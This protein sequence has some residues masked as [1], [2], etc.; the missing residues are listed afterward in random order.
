MGRTLVWL[1]GQACGGNTIS[2]LNARNP[3]LCTFLETVGI[4]VIYHPSLSLVWGK[5]LERLLRDLSARRR[6]LDLFVFEGAIP[7]GPRNTGTYCTLGNLP[8]RDVVRTLAPVARYVLA[9]GNCAAHGGMPALPPNPTG[10][11]GLQWSN[12]SPGGIL[13]AGFQSRGGLPVINITGCPA[14]PHLVLH[15]LHLLAEDRLR[16]AD[17]D[18]HGRPRAFYSEAG[19]CML[20]PGEG[21]HH[22]ELCRRCARMGW[23]ITNTDPERS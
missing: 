18:P 19:G 2:M 11:T 7:S 3:D 14:P 5:E 17:L 21:S 4:E 8:I 10:A 13:P 12:T 15:A 23:Q 9:V 6:P 22:A 16:Q 1:Q 20:P